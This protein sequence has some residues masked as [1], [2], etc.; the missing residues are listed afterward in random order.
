MKHENIE[1]M[2]NVRPTANIEWWTSRRYGI[3]GN[4]IGRWAIGG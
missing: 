2:A 3:Q 4:N 1:G